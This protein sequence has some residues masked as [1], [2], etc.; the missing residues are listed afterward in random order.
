MKKEI[1]N[2]RINGRSYEAIITPELTLYELLKDRL[3]LT[4]TK[5]SCGVGECGSCTIL[6]DGKPAL[7][8]STLAIAVRDKEILTIEGLAK[9]PRLHPIQ[10]AFVDGGRDPVRVLHAR[11]GLDGQS[12]VGGEPESDPAGSKGGPGREPVPV[13]RIC[14]DCRRRSG[15]G[16]IHEE[17][18]RPVKG[19]LSIVGKRVPRWGAHEK[20]T[21]SA[22]FTVDISLPGMLIGKVLTSP[23]AHANIISIDKSK[24]ER[25]PGVEAVITF[26]DIPATPYAPNRH[27]LILYKPDDEIRDMYVLS[28]KARFVGD[29]I[30]AVAA[31]DGATARKALGLIEVKYEVLPAL[32][33][34]LEAMRPGAPRVHDFAENNVSLHLDFPLTRGSVEEGLRE[35]D[36]VVEHTFRTSRQ[37]TSQ[38]E[39]WSCVVDFGFDGRLTIWSPAQSPFLL[40]RKIAE[41]FDMPEGM[42]RWITP[43]VGGSFGKF[44]SLVAEPVCIA[45]ARKTGKTGADGIQQGGGFR[46][47]R[48]PPD[49]RRHRYDRREEGRH[50]YRSP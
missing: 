16:G 9:G 40:R 45:L 22:K 37:Q 7:A 1:A 23:H 34:P 26:E 11:N 36:F 25:L 27:D 35:A 38:L 46:R 8:C 32:L 13:H 18:R 48:G 49:V 6:V 4:G 42:I 43:H 30:A 5:R 28:E 15:G 2:F 12:P 33:D 21:G 14:E 47:N 39:P 31:V 41:L 17:G 24:A 29:R 20:A 19:E 50:D 10:Q 44:G 3:D